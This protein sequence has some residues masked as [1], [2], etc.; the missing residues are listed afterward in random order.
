VRLAVVVQR[1]GAEISGGAELHARYIAEHLAARHEVEVL[2]TCAR[3]YVTWRDELPP[4]EDR[5]NGLRVRRFPVDRTRSP[6]DFGAWS[7][8]VFER[9]HSVRDELSWLEAEGP[10]SRALVG[11]V[12]ASAPRFDYFLFFSYRYYLAFHGARAVP[13]QAILVPTAERDPAIGLSIFPPVFR[14]VRAIMF[15]SLEERAMIRAASG[16]DDLPGVVVGVGSDV[17][18]RTDPVRF[19]RRFDVPGRFVV[20][21][22]RVDENKG[23]PQLFDYF[24]RH[25][26]ARR[27]GLTLVLAGHSILP[28][29]AH[30]QIRHV[31]FVSDEDKFDAMAGAEA[32]IMP[33]S[34]ESLSMVALESW[35]LGR[36]VL[37]NGHCDVL[38]GQCLRSN[39]GLFYD[40]YDEFNEALSVLTDNPILN[41]AMGEN[42]RSYFARHYAWP[43]IER[44]YE[45]VLERLAQEDRERRARPRMETLPGW[46][47]R[48]RRTV[49]PARTVLDMLP[50]GA[51]APA[52][53][54]HDR[55]H[56]TEAPR[57]ARAT[58]VR[59]R[60]RERPAD[61]RRRG[62]AGHRG[63][64]AR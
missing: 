2:T 51:V 18:A 60:E 39:A 50:A 8:T 28:I 7:Q 14:G 19:R 31:G 41:R 35:A 20:Y 4:G 64:R 21:V 16:R 24:Q 54:R 40:D 5:V 29:P 12:R 25:L 46:F 36:P 17:P 26:A 44:K 37:A 48:R 13:S 15:N 11:H 43:V 33:S 61:S 57:P 10:T 27:S 38:R 9:V 47:G 58:G 1:Y 49:P 63:R 22:G 56:P 62:D 23:C 42:G 45:E 3:D 55:R 52:P 32:L 30:P 34:F 53:R 59:A 6:E